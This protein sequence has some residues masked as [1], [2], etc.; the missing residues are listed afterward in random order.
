MTYS[1]TQ[2]TQSEATR[3]VDRI[4]RGRVQAAI[5]KQTSD[6]GTFYNFTL[7]RS[8]KDNDGN[9]HSTSSFSLQDALLVAKVADMA[10]GRIRK[11]MDADYVAA[12]AEAQYDEDVV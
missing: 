2:P 12:N 9:Y 10:D 6:K 7:Q 4:R 3:P 11:L 8:Y 1:E 5:W